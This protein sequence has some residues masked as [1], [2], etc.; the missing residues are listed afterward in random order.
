MPIRDF[1]FLRVTEDNYLRPWLPIRIIN[2]HNGLSVDTFGLIDT[3]ADE[4]S[5]PVF[6]AE[7]L[8]HDLEKGLPKEVKTAGSFP[9]IF[10]LVGNRSDGK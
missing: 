8:G 2:P 4:C 6:I 7:E 9:L 5:V 10:S 3:G 1:P